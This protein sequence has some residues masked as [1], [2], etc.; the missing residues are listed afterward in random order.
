METSDLAVELRKKEKVNVMENLDAMFQ[1]REAV[2]RSQMFFKIF[3][4][5]NFLRT[6]QGKSCIRDPS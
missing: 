6:S 5:K 2:C 3:V 1:I 4:L